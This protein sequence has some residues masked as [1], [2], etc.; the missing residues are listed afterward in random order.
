MFRPHGS[1]SDIGMLLS[2]SILSALSSLASHC[3]RLRNNALSCPPTLATGTIGTPA[4][5][6]SL[7]VTHA[8][9]E[10]DLVTLPRRPEDLVVA[11]GIDQQRCAGFQCYAG[12]FVVGGD[13]AE[14]A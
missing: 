11:A 3:P 12:I 10:V 5:R 1:A 14:L 2:R 6:A 8:A 13:G 9:A 7:H 4:S